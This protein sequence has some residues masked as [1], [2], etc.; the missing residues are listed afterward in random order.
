MNNQDNVLD[1]DNFV[2]FSGCRIP[3]NSKIVVL[4][5]RTK[6]FDNLSCCNEFQ[7]FG[8][9]V[10]QNFDNLQLDNSE[11]NVDEYHE[12]ESTDSVKWYQSSYVMKGFKDYC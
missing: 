10:H 11:E 5:L 9:I 4:D 1:N 3:R 7:I 8:D 12:M 6:T 2:F